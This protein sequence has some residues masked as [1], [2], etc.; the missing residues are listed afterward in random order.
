MKDN[1]PVFVAVNDQK[2]VVG[3]SSL[4]RFHER[5]GYQFTVD[6]SVY[7]A[8]GQR[9][10]GIGTLLMPPLINGAKARG[11]HAIIAL[12]GANNES[13]IRL[14]ARFGF[15]RAGLLKQVGFKFDRWLDLVYMERLV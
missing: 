10:N 15:E 3:W 4:N 13:S 8:A 6:N 5:M 12:I 14:H 1:Y 7:V 11:L 9:G 2:T